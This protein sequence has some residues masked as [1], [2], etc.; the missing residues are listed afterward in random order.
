MKRIVPIF[1][2]HVTERGELLLTPAEAAP[3]R[4][5]LQALA[6]L[7]VE[8]VV[9][10]RRT[11]RSLKQNAY[12]HDVPFPLLLEAC[13]YDSIE[14][15]KYDLMGTCWGWTR[16]KAGHEIPIKAHTSELTTAEGAYFTEWLVQFGAQLPRPVIIPLPNEAE[17]A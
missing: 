11:Q 4:R 12:W 17:A 2:G 16:T 15:L 3:R 9:R 10:K 5:H 6:G 1:T 7:D 14:E 13:G 8:I